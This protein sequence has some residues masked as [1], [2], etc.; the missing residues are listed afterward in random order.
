MFANN[1]MIMKLALFVALNLIGSLCFSQQEE[2][3]HWQ[4]TIFL[5]NGDSLKG[6]VLLYQM[7]VN[8]AHNTS[9][10]HQHNYVRFEEIYGGIDSEKNATK[11]DYVQILKIRIFLDTV[12]YKSLKNF[13]KKN[14]VY[15][16]TAEYRTIPNTMTLWK[17][18]KEKGAISILEDNISPTTWR[19][20]TSNRMILYTNGKVID[21]YSKVSGVW[22]NLPSVLLK[23]INN[24]YNKKFKKSDFKN[25]G[26]L[27]ID[28]I[29]DNG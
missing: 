8:Y 19:T 24:R 27:M 14:I 28:Y 13:V 5:Q 10:Y 23:F 26:E 29:L 11:I 12:M 7:N 2:W 17:L 3:Q 25:D 4:G 18:R 6:E 9:I 1:R 15:R 20:H 21:M 22:S 16:K